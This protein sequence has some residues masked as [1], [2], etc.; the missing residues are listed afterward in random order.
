M[1]AAW[2]KG[3]YRYWHSVKRPFSKRSFYDFGRHA[4]NLRREYN[5]TKEEIETLDV[6]RYVNESFDIAKVAYE[7]IE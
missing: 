3:L 1:H 5:F 2:D 6:N 4:K 7:G